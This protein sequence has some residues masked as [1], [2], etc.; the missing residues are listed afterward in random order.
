[1]QIF[2]DSATYSQKDAAKKL[3]KS[4]SWFERARWAGNGPRYIKVGRSVL[5]LGKDLNEWL[6][7]QARA[8][9]GHKK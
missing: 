6:A 2:E 5:Y 7:A 8:N 9:T 4:E 1:M 3:Q